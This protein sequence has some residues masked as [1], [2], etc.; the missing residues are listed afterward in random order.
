MLAQGQFEGDGL[1]SQIDPIGSVGCVTVTY[2]DR[3]HYIKAMVSRL[4][5][6]GVSTIVVVDNGSTPTSA[7]TLQELTSEQTGIKIVLL[8]HD[9]NLGSAEGFNTGL[10]YARDHLKEDF[11]WL[12]DDDNLPQQDA[13]QALKQAY[14]QLNTGQELVCLQSIRKPG[15]PSV[16][17]VTLLQPR[18]NFL[19]FHFPIIMNKVA[20]RIDL[21]TKNQSNKEEVPVKIS[22]APYGGFFFSR[23]CFAVIGLPDPSFTLYMDDFEYTNRVVTQ[24]GS[25]WLIPNSIVEDLENS[26]H[27]QTSKKPLLYHSVLDTTHEFKVYY[28][29]RNMIYFYEKRYGVNNTLIYSLNRFIL[30]TFVQLSALLRGKNNRLKLVRQAIKDGKEGKMGRRFELP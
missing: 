23:K 11:F 28:T 9:A 13:L 12:L 29:V 3:S 4:S 25:I 1:T 2:G 17:T 6:I 21:K 8:R 19:G 20:E 16:H 30:M 7:S 18:N 15:M 5:T 26:H 10:T 14:N 24:G 27:V 22:A